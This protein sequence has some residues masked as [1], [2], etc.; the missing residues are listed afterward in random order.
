M[1]IKSFNCRFCEKTFSRKSTL[2]VHCLSHTKEKPFKCNT[3]SKTFAQIVHL[4]NHE[5]IHNGEKPYQCAFCSR[6]FS[7]KCNL[8]IH[9]RIHTKDTKYKCTVCGKMY[10]ESRSLKRHMKV[11]QDSSLI[12]LTNEDIST[13]LSWV[14]VKLYVWIK[15]LNIITLIQHMELYWKYILSRLFIHSY[16]LCF[17]INKKYFYL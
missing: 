12:V 5:R 15:L 10:Y 1:G 16:K 2:K 6:K 14:F 3:C 8:V 7:V 13:L 9:T 4:K 17:L 11:H